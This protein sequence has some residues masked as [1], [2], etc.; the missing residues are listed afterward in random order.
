MVAE[1]RGTVQGYGKAEKLDPPAQGGD[2]PSGWYLTGVVVNASARRRGLGS[3]LTA[4]RIR[5]L[6]PA[7]TEVWF[8]ANLQNR[9]SVA[10]HE[11]YGFRLETTDFRIPGVTFEG[12]RG[13]L[14]RL[15]LDHS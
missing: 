10:L 13:G 14:F 5:R 9:A 7:A 6:H 4:A 8:C 11:R 12:G 1:R 2:A 15:G 3:R